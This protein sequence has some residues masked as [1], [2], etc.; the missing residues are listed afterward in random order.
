MSTVSAS[1][2]QW[3]VIVF[4][5][6]NERKTKMEYK[7]SIGKVYADCVSCGKTFI[8]DQYANGFCNYD[9]STLIK[10]VA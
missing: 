9:K 1:E 7:L 4:R 6:N 2:C 10:Q 8:I 3:L 5:Y